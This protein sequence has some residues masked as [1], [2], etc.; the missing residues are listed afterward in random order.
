MFEKINPSSPFLLVKDHLFLVSFWFLL[1]LPLRAKGTFV[2]SWIKG[3]PFF[4]P[5]DQS[6]TDFYSGQKVNSLRT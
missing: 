6:S 2:S 1:R 5:A 4:Q 3:N